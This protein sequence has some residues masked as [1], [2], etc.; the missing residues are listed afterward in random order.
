MSEYFSNFPKIRYDI[1]GNNSINPDYTIGTNLLIRQ[2]LKDVVKKDVSIYYPYVIP[3]NITR[4][5]T[6]ATQIYGDVKFTWTIFLVNN[7]LDPVWEWPMTTS[8]FQKH[9]ENKY[10]SIAISKSTIHHY[11]YIW[12]ERVEA[13][14][15]SDPIPEQFIEVDYDTY[16]SKDPDFRRIIYA[17]EY[18]SDLNESR[19]EIQL[20]QPIFATKVLTES[21]KIFR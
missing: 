4:A 17:Y 7:I 15:T 13:T 11:E 14:G 19:R 9:L 21:R 6:L 18:E 3:D 12:S 20:I 10:G 5:D 1:H 8:I 16:L 2:K